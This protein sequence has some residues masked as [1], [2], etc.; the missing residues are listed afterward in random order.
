METSEFRKRLYKFTLELIHV[1]DKLPARDM[2]AY[3]LGDQLFRS[4]TSIIG[5]YIEGEAASSTR[6]L[7]NYRS[8]SLKSA[9]ESILWFSLLKDSRRLNPASANESIRE[10]QEYVKIF[11]VAILSLKKKQS[12][13]KKREA[14]KS[15]A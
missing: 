13:Q 7:I 6:D 5:N 1:I 4:G 2:V 9:K 3:R 11:S 14:I 15:S 12:Q 8:N 10:L